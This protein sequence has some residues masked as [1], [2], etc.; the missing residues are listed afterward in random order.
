MGEDIKTVEID[1]RQEGWKQHPTL[2]R[3]WILYKGGSQ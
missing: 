1:P 3:T 2:E